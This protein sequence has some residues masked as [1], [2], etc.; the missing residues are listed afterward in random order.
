MELRVLDGEEPVHEEEN[1]V[2]NVPARG[3]AVRRI[4]Q[5]YGGPFDKIECRFMA[6][7]EERP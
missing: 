6:A 1:L 3:R 7:Q 5:N 2:R 4:I